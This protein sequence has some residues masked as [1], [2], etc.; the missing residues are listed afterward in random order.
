MTTV[1]L[2]DDQLELRSIHSAYLE[3]H[4]YRVLTAVDGETALQ[5]A[6][7]AR[8]DIIILDHS[9]PRR[10]GLEVARELKQDPV[11]AGITIV[12]LT[13]HSYGTVGRRAREAGCASFLSKPCGP[14]RLLHEVALYA[15]AT[16][17]PA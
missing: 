4:G 16:P 9:L 15:K 8:P 14:R 6:R 7:E 17:Q 12:M 1:L 13:A 10:T 2:V 11:T 5:T 3:T